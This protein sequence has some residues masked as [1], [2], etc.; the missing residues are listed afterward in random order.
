MVAMNLNPC[1]F[2]LQ[3]RMRAYHLAIEY[4]RDVRI[5]LLLNLVEPLVGSIPWSRFAHRQDYFPGFLIEPKKIDHARIG[6]PR[7]SRLMLMLVAFTRSEIIPNCPLSLPESTGICRLRFVMI[8]P[9][10]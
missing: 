2:S 4:K 8:V 5:K 6:N 3:L 10:A 7:L 9:V 1:R